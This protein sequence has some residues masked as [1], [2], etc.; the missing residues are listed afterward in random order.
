MS[1]LRR[2]QSFAAA[3]TVSALLAVLATPALAGDA[4]KNVKFKVTNN[5]FE[6]REIEIRQVKFR[7]PHN[8]GQVQT[9]DVK[10]KTC[11]HGLTCTTNGDNL[12][13]ADKVDLDDIQVVFRYRE[14]DGGWSK[15][16]LTQ[17][18]TPALRKCKE[19][20]EYGPIVV[21]DSA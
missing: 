20:K 3:A 1:L 15:E 17:P 7:N 18:F 14:H 16:F 10:N 12:S 21:K 2:N 8:G 11:N 19:G 5:H 13:N 6:G 9:E 4:C